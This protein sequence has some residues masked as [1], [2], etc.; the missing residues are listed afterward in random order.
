MRCYRQ[1]ASNILTICISATRR[2]RPFPTRRLKAAIGPSRVAPSVYEAQQNHSATVGVT[3]Q[4]C[5]KVMRMTGHDVTLVPYGADNWPIGRIAEIHAGR[6]AGLP[7]AVIRPGAMLRINGR[8]LDLPPPAPTEAEVPIAVRVVAQLKRLCGGWNGAAGRFV[9]RYFTFLDRQIDRHRAEIDA[10][11]APFD[12][13]F[14][15]EDFIH[16]APL[17]LPRAFLFAPVTPRSSEDAE[18]ADFVKVDFAWWLG[19]RMVAVLLAPSPLTPLMARRRDERLT[20]AG[21]GLAPCT[22]A[23][24]DDVGLGW[25]AETLGPEGSRFWEGE[26]LP[27]APCPSG[28]SDF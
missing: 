22:M 11:L 9:D 19:D 17:P 16:S 26:A 20:A 7:L 10:R 3:A 4:L 24:L 23:D 25:F 27:S 6:M 2:I 14:R 18:P 1:M 28:L 5:F 21:I 12:G 15:A 13:L 8:A